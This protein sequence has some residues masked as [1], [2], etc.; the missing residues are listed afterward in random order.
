MDQPKSSLILPPAIN[1]SFYVSPQYTRNFKHIAINV[2]GN[3]GSRTVHEP[4]P[5]DDLLMDWLENNNLAKLSRA[6]KGA[7][8]TDPTYLLELNTGTVSVD[9]YQK[10]EEVK[11]KQTLYR[12]FVRIRSPPDMTLLPPTLTETLRILNYQKHQPNDEFR[13]RCPQFF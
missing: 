8:H 3:E 9:T 10:V 1:L 13:K 12:H 5:T 2:D 7:D 11:D 4:K 6:Y